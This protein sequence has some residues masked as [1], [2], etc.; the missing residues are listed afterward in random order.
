MM[1]V[2][3]LWVIMI[4]QRKMLML[5]MEFASCMTRQI[6]LGNMRMKPIFVIGLKK[7]LWIFMQSIQVL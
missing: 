3:H 2:T 6:I 1:P 4:I 7:L 5:I